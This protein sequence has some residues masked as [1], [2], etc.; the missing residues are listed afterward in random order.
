MPN[1]FRFLLPFLIA[2]CAVYLVSSSPA[3]NNIFLPEKQ[4]PAYHAA[5]FDYIANFNDDPQLEDQFLRGDSS[6]PALFLLGSS[7]LVNNSGA[8]PYRFITKN[9]NTP[10][11]AIGHAGNQCFSMFCQ[12]LANTERLAHS[13]IVFIISPGWFESKNALG[14]SSEVFLEYN[15]ER[16]LQK[17]LSQEPSNAF[18]I[19]ASQRI[20]E[21]YPEFNAPS[22]PIK[23][24][25]FSGCA[26][27]SPF[28]KA[29]YLPLIAVDHF[30]LNKRKRLLPDPA[31]ESWKADAFSKHTQNKAINWDSLM[32]QAKVN[33]LAAS[34]N[35][36]LGI[37]L[38]IF[39]EK[40]A[41][42]SR[43]LFPAIRSGRISECF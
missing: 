5:P 30:L 29:A 36:T 9:F 34:E 13:R 33:A 39:K 8:V 4:L 14:T 38:S 10:V 12:L 18:K 31:K 23:L 3:F 41:V 35:N 22:L 32:S 17:I 43:Y 26:S 19:Y 16:F 24:L 27:R 25:N 20:A 6:G 7:E 42:S 28:H 40:A 1:A 11:K 37:I 15:S 2:L 21:M